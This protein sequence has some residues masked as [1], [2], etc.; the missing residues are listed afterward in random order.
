MRERRRR[1][2]DSIETEQ[3]VGEDV[4]MKSGSVPLG[5]SE[6]KRERGEEGRDAGALIPF[7]P[8][9]HA[10]TDVCIYIYVYMYIYIYLTTDPSNILAPSQQTKHERAMTKQ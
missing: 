6:R 7:F 5:A 3:D 10:I 2:M 4:C 1:R 8:N 9:Q